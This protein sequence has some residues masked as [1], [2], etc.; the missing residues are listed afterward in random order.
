MIFNINKSNLKYQML[1]NSNTK[2]SLTKGDTIKT[3]Y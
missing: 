3:D 2:N 1:N